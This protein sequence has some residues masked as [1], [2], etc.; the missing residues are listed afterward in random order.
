MKVEVV[1]EMLG[2][3]QQLTWFVVQEDFIEFSHCEIFMLYIFP[4]VS[5]LLCV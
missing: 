2:F 1:S 4:F 5:V 3:C